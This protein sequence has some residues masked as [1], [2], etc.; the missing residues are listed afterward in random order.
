MAQNLY[1]GTPGRLLVLLALLITVV[2]VSAWRDALQR[3]VTGVARYP[4]AVGD[5]AFFNPAVP[6]SVRS[7]ERT[8]DLLPAADAPETRRDDRMFHL[9]LETP[10][11]FRLYTGRENPDPATD[12]PLFAKVAPGRYLRLKVEIRPPERAGTTPETPSR[13]DDG[14]VFPE[15]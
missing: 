12:P 3:P 4:T 1:R 6:A 8:L 15:E 14:G 2:V 11:P 10:L 13:A 5:S 7:G 9:P